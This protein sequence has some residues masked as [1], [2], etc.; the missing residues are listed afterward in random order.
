LTIC[1]KLEAEGLKLP[2][3]ALAGGFT[4]EDQVY[5]ALAIGAPY[6]T[7]VGICRATMAA[8]MVGENT[9][10]ALSEGTVPP[11]LKKYGA[12]RD[13]LFW[14]LPELRSLYGAAADE[15]STGAIGAYSYIKRIAFGIQHF[16]AL[17]RKFDVKYIDQRD[18][19]PLTLDAKSL[20]KGQWFD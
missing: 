11:H 17:N 9:G 1:S 15:M 8:A 14:E 18:V 13:E 20:L 10:L 16:A 5:K 12:T 19:I 3:M 4:S 7:A 6:I 2:A